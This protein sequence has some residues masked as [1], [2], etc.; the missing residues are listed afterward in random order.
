M[1]FS[2]SIWLKMVKWGKINFRMNSTVSKKKIAFANLIYF[3]L[4]K[5]DNIDLLHILTAFGT[6]I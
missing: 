2:N 1:T 5:R 4:I 6:R 3:E